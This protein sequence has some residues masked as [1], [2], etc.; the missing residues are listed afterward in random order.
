MQPRREAAAARG[1]NRPL[2]HIV[3]RPISLVTAVP[4]K[5]PQSW[6]VLSAT[7]ANAS[8]ATV[9]YADGGCPWLELMSLGGGPLEPLELRL[10]AIGLAETGSG[11]AHAAS[12]EVELTDAYV[13]FQPPSYRNRIDRG[14]GRRHRHYGRRRV[15]LGLHLHQRD[16]SGLD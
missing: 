8:G 6:R 13:R 4:S 5:R 15:S 16:R 9:T 12:I 7:C 3:E 14:F 11:D 10:S 2:T 1:R